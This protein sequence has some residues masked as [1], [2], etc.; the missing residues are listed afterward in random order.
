MKKR[1]NGFLSERNIDHGGEV[2]SYIKELH[3][4]LWDFIGIHKPDSQGSIQDHLDAALELANNK[5]ICIEIYR[6]PIRD[7]KFKIYA[8]FIGDVKY[9]DVFS[10]ADRLMNVT[11]FKTNQA[12]I[13]KDIY[14]Y[15]A[16]HN[17][18]IS[19]VRIEAGNFTYE[20]K[21]ETV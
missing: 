16:G 6:H 18:P 15:F 4:Y 9:A 8:Y 11:N 7:R 14:E 13:L 3:D 20:Y 2:F 5:D 21:E 1:T 10:L 17:L 19:K 12:A